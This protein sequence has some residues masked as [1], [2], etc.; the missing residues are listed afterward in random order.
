MIV[1]LDLD[2]GDIRHYPPEDYPGIIALRLA[3]KSR[4]SVLSALSQMIPLL[5]TQPLAGCLWAVEEQQ[6]RIRQSGG[7]ASP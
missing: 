4:Q 3:N 2:F 6:V 1:I 5:A 7:S